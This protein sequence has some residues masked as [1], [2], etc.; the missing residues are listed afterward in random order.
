MTRTGVCNP[1]QSVMS[2]TSLEGYPE[3]SAY[4]G[5]LKSEILLC[6]LKPI[7]RN[8]FH[9]GLQ[10]PP[11]PGIILIPL[12]AV[13]IDGNSIVFSNV[14]FL[15]SRCTVL[16]TWRGWGWWDGLVVI[17]KVVGVVFIITITSTHENNHDCKNA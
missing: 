15:N 2:Q 7:L 1:H 9:S 4:G 11:S 16:F 10:A 8:I 14:F 6:P 5:R 12:G 13:F 3:P 17:V